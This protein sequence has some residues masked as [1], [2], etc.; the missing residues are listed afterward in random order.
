MWTSP[1]KAGCAVAD[2]NCMNRFL[3]FAAL[4]ILATLTLTG[5]AAIPVTSQAPGNAGSAATS[6][7]PISASSAAILARLVKLTNAESAGPGGDYFWLNGKAKINPRV[8]PA[9]GHVAFAA[10]NR[11][12]SAVARATLT[13]AMFAA[14]KGSRQGSPLD[15]PSWPT[16]EHAAITYQ[17]TGR[18]YH[19][20]FYNRSHSVSDALAGVQS[21]TS[22]YNFTTGTR[23]Q[24]VGADQ[25]GG[26]R[27][28][29]EM[30]EGYWKAHPGS[31]AT[32]SYQTTPLYSGAE[33]MPRGSVVDERSS[34]GAIN[35]E[36]VVVNDAEGYRINYVT[37]AQTQ[38]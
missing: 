20:Y 21:Y 14:S 16:N 35:A 38:G 32:I 4:P 17:L 26:M 9:A 27:A 36:I 25:N 13:Y 1:L 7:A 37:G 34:D 29:E 5:C 23:P 28:A 33:T 8:M 2:S 18:T 12:R 24:N 11:G 19:G 3:S 22:P 30:A 10:D 15:P 31:K 6:A